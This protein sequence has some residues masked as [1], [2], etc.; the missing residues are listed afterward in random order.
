MEPLSAYIL[1]R[2]S[3]EDLGE[4]LGRLEPVVDEILVLD[5]GSTD[6]TREIAESFPKVRWLH[7]ALD[8][9]S[10]QRNYALGQCAARHVFF[11]DSDEIPDDELIQGLRRLRREGFS[12][13]AYDVRR[14]W[15]VLSG[16]RIR[17]LYPVSS[18]DYPVRL[19]DKAKVRYDASSTMVHETL[20]G[21]E[22]RKRLPGRL[23]H[24]TFR[25]REE[26]ARKLKLYSD[27]AA[28]DLIARRDKSP[29]WTRQVFN[30]CFAFI[31]WYF[32]KGGFREGWTG[33]IFAAYAFNYT[34]EKYRKAARLAKGEAL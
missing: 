30:P 14:D 2:D 17:S 18:P 28:R 12:A 32:G 26:I 5:S 4:I 19:I 20:S 23:R 6:R 3:E 29:H 9:F 31:K 11:L 15:F 13:E 1:T 16:K 10:S 7:R 21:H 25:T 22:I 27:L 33:L 8:D 24:H 34:R